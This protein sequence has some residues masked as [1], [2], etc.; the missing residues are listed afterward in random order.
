MPRTGVI[1][2]EV[3]VPMP[4]SV[5]I[6][7]VLGAAVEAFLMGPLVPPR[8]PIMEPLVP[9]VIAGMPVVIVMRKAGRRWNA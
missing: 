6:G 3:M 7:A 5:M 9:R 4:Q 1:V 2:M 8:G